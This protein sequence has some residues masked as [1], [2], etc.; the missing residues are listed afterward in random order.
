MSAVNRLNWHGQSCFNE[1]TKHKLTKL[2]FICEPYLQ[3]LFQ[4]E[5]MN[6]LSV[7][8]LPSRFSD[9]HFCAQFVELVPKVFRLKPALYVGELLAA[10]TGRCRRTWTSWATIGVRTCRS[11]PFGSW[12]SVRVTVRL[13]RLLYQHFCNEK[14]RTIS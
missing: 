11:H 8:S 3:E 12:Q 14:T 6:S 1:I 13:C 5:A 4:R 10:A 7:C 2:C 9:D